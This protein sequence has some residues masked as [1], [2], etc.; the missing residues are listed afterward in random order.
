MGKQARPA[1]SKKEA[2]R[3]KESARDKERL[4]PAKQNV[5]KRSDERHEAE[6]PDDVIVGRNAVVESLKSGRGINKILVASGERE[7]SVREIVALARERGVVCEMV[8]R[9]RIGQIAAG[10]RHQGV[11]AYVAPVPYVELDEII[12]SARARGREPF[13]VLLDELEDPHNLGAILRTADAAGVDGVVILKRRSCPLSATVAKTSAGAIEYV[14]VARIGN[15]AQTLKKLKDD[16]FWVIGADMDGTQ[17]YYDADYRGAI[18][19]VIG[20]EGHGISTLTKKCCDFIV[21]IPM[22]GH[23]NSLNASVAGSILMYEAMKKRTDQ[24]V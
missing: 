11:L 13:I 2:K 20:G 6:L 17:S 5:Q 10:H 21:S 24:V 4:R 1:F 15:I 14:P 22:V 16:G 12:S 18:V 23:I 8:S 3:E 19:L 9:D 7:G